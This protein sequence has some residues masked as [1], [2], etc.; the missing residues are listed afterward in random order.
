MSEFLVEIRLG[1]LKYDSHKRRSVLLAITRFVT[2]EY[3]VIRQW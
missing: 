3:F 1:E 2:I